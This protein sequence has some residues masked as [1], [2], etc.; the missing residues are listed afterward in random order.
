MFLTK[1]LGMKILKAIQITRFQIFR[2][3]RWNITKLT[4]FWRHCDVK[5]VFYEQNCHIWIPRK[6]SYKKLFDDFLTHFVFWP[7]NLH[8]FYSSKRQKWT[9]MTSI[10]RHIDVKK[11]FKNKNIHF[12]ILRKTSYKKLFD[13]FFTHFV[14]WAPNLHFIFL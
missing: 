10:W 8:F 11:K 2:Q 7:P 3:K 4:S 6:I 5:I 1:K 14:F 9:K 13:Y 12:W